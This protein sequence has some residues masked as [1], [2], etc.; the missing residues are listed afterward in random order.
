MDQSKIFGI[1]LAKTGTTTL[2]EALRIL[3]YSAVHYPV[4]LQ[5]IEEYDAATDNPIADTFEM[6]DRTYPG[7][8]FIY[9]VRQRDEW[10]RSCKT[11]W[12]RF[13]DKREE[14]KELRE[15]LYGTA[16]FDE[17]LFVKAYDRHEKRVRDYFSDRPADLL[18]VNLCSG[19]NEWA[20]ICSFLDREV[21]DSPFPHLNTTKKEFDY[22]IDRIGWLPAKAKKQI[23][24]IRRK[25]SRMFSLGQ[26]TS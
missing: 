5:G 19:N 16:E 15:R 18:V 14:A 12:A 22:R 8:K 24:R 23:R 7:S 3:G 6:L 9:T 25:T 17:E 10:L 2:T 20:P 13:V 11:H 4:G 21:P 26:S 1:G